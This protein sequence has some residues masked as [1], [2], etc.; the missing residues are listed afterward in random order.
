MND[1]LPS[2]QACAMRVSR[3]DTDGVPLPGAS[4]LYVTEGIIELTATPDVSAGDEV[5]V[6]NGKG[7][8]CISYREEDK[9][10]RLNVDLMI[11]APDPELTE[12]LAGGA[13]QTSGAA[14]GYKME[15]LNVGTDRTGVSIELW[16]RRV[17]SDGDSDA[18]FP[19]LWHVYP[20]VKLK[21]G[22]RRFFN[23][24]LENPFNGFAIENPNWFDG[25]ANDWPVDSDR[26][27]AFLPT[28]S[29]PDADCG[30]QTLVAS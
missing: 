17:S 3:L 20:K 13:V 7:D 26:A 19:Y 4:N 18:E 27:Y 10:K 24:A 16:S 25:P 14:V 9:I 6:K 23:G 15:A 2:I 1:C 8:I 12:L 11:C 30:Y 22:A 28:A 21:I 5:E 29:L